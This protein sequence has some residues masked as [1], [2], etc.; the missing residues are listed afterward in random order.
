M[1]RPAKTSVGVPSREGRTLPGG[2]RINFVTVRGPTGRARALWIAAEAGRERNG[3]ARALWI[4]GAHSRG[5]TV[6]EWIAPEADR[7]RTE[8]HSEAM[9]G[10]ARRGIKAAGDIRVCPLREAVVGAAV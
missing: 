6:A 10:G 4:A 3:R 1:R 5:Q 9:N 7:G 2:M 8:A